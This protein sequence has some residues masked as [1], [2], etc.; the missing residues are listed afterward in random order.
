MKCAGGESKVSSNSRTKDLG[1]ELS[2]KPAI[3]TTFDGPSIPHQRFTT[4]TTAPRIP[5]YSIPSI[6]GASHMRI[7]PLAC[8]SRDRI[9]RARDGKESRILGA[10]DSTHDHLCDPLLTSERP[11]Q[12]RQKTVLIWRSA[13]TQ[14]SSL[15]NE[16]FLPCNTSLSNAS[17]DTPLRS[18]QDSRE[19]HQR[20]RHPHT[21]HSSYHSS[22]DSPPLSAN[23][24][25]A[26][27]Q[28]P[29]PPHELQP[30]GLAPAAPP[31]WPQ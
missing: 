23:H 5:Q 27:S 10:P 2:S 8:S 25:P 19:Y 28:R 13:R 24:S 3:P 17:S 26:P 1:F 31:P 4:T 16:P 21:H 20:R 15:H 11:R 29:E 7:L 22:R 14:V 18:R 12:W 9:F 30:G 6:S